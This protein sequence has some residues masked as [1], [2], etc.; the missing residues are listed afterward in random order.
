MGRYYFPTYLV[1]EVG[2]QHENQTGNRTS[3]G[4]GL[5]E[6]GEV[7]LEKEEDHM[8]DYN[9]GGEGVTMSSVT[10]NTKGAQKEE[11]VVE[12]VKTETD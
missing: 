5:S 8:T 12:R 7:K 6:A 2:S 4:P 11:E 10:G 3:D 9:G 1:T